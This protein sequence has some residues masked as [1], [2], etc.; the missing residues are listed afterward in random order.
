V[1]KAAE[2]QGLLGEPLRRKAVLARL[3]S[4]VHLQESGDPDVPGAGL[5]V[6]RLGD[7]QAIDGMDG[8]ERVSTPAEDARAETIPHPPTLFI[9]PTP[10]PGPSL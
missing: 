6:Q 10:E 1:L 4:Q 2:R 5:A 7:L 3:A 8:A 9:S